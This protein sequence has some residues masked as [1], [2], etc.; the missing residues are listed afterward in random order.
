MGDP[1][2]GPSRSTV[3]TPRPP[4]EELSA[5]A[6]LAST[7]TA[8]A[9]EAAR[10]VPR[11]QVMAAAYTRPIIVSTDKLDETPPSF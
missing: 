8:A 1:G 2:I 10:R 11:R 9:A 4:S 7:I 6:A 3:G 5:H